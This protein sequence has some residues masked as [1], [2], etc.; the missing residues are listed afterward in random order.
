MFNNMPAIVQ[1]LLCYIISL[2]ESSLKVVLCP[3]YFWGKLASG[4]LRPLL[5]SHRR[6]ESQGSLQIFLVTKTPE[7]FHCVKM[8]LFSCHLELLLPTKCE[9]GALTMLFCRIDPLRISSKIWDHQVTVQF[10]L[11]FINTETSGERTILG[12]LSNYDSCKHGS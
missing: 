5:K 9:Q 3:F 2:Y 7:Y 8:L 10:V 4:I 1:I 6:A 12:P 11:E